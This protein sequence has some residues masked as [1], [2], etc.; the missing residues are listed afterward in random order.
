MLEF[1]Q[2]RVRFITGLVVI[3]GII[4]GL[5]ASQARAQAIPAQDLPTIQQKQNDIQRRHA[6]DVKKRESQR[7]EFIDTPPDGL[8]TPKVEVPTGLEDGACVD[9]ATFDVQGAEPLKTHHTFTRR[10]RELYSSASLKF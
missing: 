3:A 6:D 9:I 5:A 2:K 7:R 10:G 8:Q 1:G 4:L